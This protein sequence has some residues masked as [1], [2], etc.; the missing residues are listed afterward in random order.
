MYDTF[1]KIIYSVHIFL[2]VPY[3]ISGVTAL[4]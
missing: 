1:A 3:A 4:H 2:K